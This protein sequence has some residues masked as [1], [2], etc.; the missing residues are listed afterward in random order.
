MQ[1]K[2]GGGEDIDW[3]NQI[4][5]RKVGNSGNTRF[6]HDAWIGVIPL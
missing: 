2:L 3:F 1:D 5:R 4:V 6:W